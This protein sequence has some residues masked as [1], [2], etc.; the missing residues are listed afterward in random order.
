VGHVA[1]V[2]QNN[3]KCF[4]LFFFGAVAMTL[5]GCRSINESTSTAEVE[6]KIQSIYLSGTSPCA[7]NTNYVSLPVMAS[8]SNATTGD[9]NLFLSDLVV[10]LR[11]ASFFDENMLMWEIAPMNNWG[12]HM[13]E[14]AFIQLPSG[15]GTNV[16]LNVI[17]SPPPVK[18]VN[19]DKI[20]R[21]VPK[22][23]YFRVADRSRLLPKGFGAIRVFLHGTGRAQIR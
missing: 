3:M 2:A 10:A 4:L 14:S 19:S 13:D 15:Q 6:F 22:V 1:T 9:L 21:D 23:L 17:C 11:R 5:S 20:T 12:I 7:L 18:L 16:T 8:L